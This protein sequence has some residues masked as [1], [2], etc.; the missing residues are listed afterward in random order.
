MVNLLAAAVLIAGTSPPPSCAAKMERLRYWANAHEEVISEFLKDRTLTVYVVPDWKAF[1]SRDVAWT[2]PFDHPDVIW[3]R[4]DFLCVSS[5]ST[6]ELTISHECYHLVQPNWSHE[7]IES[8]IRRSVGP[9]DYAGYRHE[10]ELMLIA[11]EKWRDGHRPRRSWWKFG[12][13]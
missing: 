5:D 1:D 8:S 10:L 12:D 2:L 9:K 11:M 6:L 13:P 4:L 7:Q 3:V